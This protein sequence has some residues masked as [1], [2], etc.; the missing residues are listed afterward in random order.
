MNVPM[1]MFMFMRTSGVSK[2]A[3]LVHWSMYYHHH[4]LSSAGVV[5]TDQ[6]FDVLTPIFQMSGK[7][8]LTGHQSTAHTW[9]RE[10]GSR[11]QIGSLA[12]RAWLV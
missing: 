4:V 2:R 6:S 7:M 11:Q 3:S 1:F 8:N 12:S 9:K 10:E 5:R